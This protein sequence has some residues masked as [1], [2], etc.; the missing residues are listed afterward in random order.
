MAHSDGGATP[1][2]ALTVGALLVVVALIAFA[3]Y[4]GR[5]ERAAPRPNVDVDLS[6]PKPTLPQTPK[7]PETPVPTPK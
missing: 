2:L 4:G 6:L 3:L 1:W 7:L 5:S